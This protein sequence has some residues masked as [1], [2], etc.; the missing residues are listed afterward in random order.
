[1]GDARM[2]LVPKWCSAS[3]SNKKPAHGSGEGLQAGKRAADC[4]AAPDAALLEI[5]KM[6]KSSNSRRRV[7]AEYASVAEYLNY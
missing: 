6:T 7:T 2:E 3:G 5:N 4:L 1:M